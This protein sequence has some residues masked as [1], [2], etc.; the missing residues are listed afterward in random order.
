MA[1]LQT[2][3]LIVLISTSFGNIVKQIEGVNEAISNTVIDKIML[4]LYNQRQLFNERIRELE[5]TISSQQRTIDRHEEHNIGINKRME[6]LQKQIEHCNFQKLKETTPRKA[7]NNTP[8]DESIKRNLAKDDAPNNKPEN[9]ITVKSTQ[10]LQIPNTEHF[11]SKRIVESNVA[12]SAYLDHNV[13]HMAAGHHIVLNQVQLND[14]NGYNH[15]TGIFT[16]P[17]SGVYL[18]S[19]SIYSHFR[20]AIVSLS[21]DGVNHTDIITYPYND[22]GSMSSNTIIIRVN[23]GQ[24][25]WLQ[26]IV[27][28]DGEIWN[29]AFQK[30][31][32]FS[33]VLLY[34]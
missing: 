30:Y 31:A 21:V 9:T 6:D 28:N 16:A 32:T 25:V 11:A 27:S 7:E 10:G 17:E 5:Q 15:F 2:I 1:T 14:G 22:H 29:N 3:V 12:F 26:N 34:Q 18:F 4:E 19:F 33:G 20:L 8:L 13:D 24:S 23:S